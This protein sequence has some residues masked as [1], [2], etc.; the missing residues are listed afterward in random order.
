MSGTADK[1]GARPQQATTR[2]EF[3]LSKGLVAPEKPQPSE[4]ELDEADRKRK[5]LEENVDPDGRELKRLDDSGAA[6]PAM[7]MQPPLSTTY[8]AA[9]SGVGMY[10]AVPSSGTPPDYHADSAAMDTG[11][12]YDALAPAALSSG[13]HADAEVAANAAQSTAMSVDG[14]GPL[15]DAGVAAPEATPASDAAPAVISEE[16]LSTVFSEA[17]RLQPVDRGRIEAFIAKTAVLDP[18]DRDVQQIVL[19]EIRTPQDDGNIVV[20]QV[21]F[22]MTFSTMEW[23]RLRRKRKIKGD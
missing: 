1:A 4:D 13:Y 16:L 19:H 7:D 22:E 8:D 18:N 23:R 17:N 15:A 11:M 2:R 20:E 21:V 5:L 9:A 14:V 10:G 3:L 6:D 12:E